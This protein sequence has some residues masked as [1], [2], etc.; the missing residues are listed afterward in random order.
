VLAKKYRLTRAED[1]K[2][3]HSQGQ[4]WVNNK[5]I[6]C[7]YHSELDFSRFGFSVSRKMGGAVVRNRI[8]RLLREVVRLHLEQVVPGWDVIIVARK[9][10]VGVTYSTVERSILALLHTSGL[11]SVE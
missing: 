5:L 3:V 7:R 4:S 1:F 8:K 9:G 10:I 6:L 11:L 2:R